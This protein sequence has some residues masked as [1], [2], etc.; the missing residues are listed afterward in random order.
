MNVIFFLLFCICAIGFLFLAPDRFLSTL[1]SGASKSATLCIAMLAGYTVWM[2][3]M[4]VWE[5]SGL[6]RGVSKRLRPLA[7]KV[8]KTTDAATLDAVC[9]N[10]SVN[11]LGI[12][13]A[14]TPYGIR[15]AALLD[16]T[17]RAEYASSLFFVLNATSIQLFPSSLVAMRTSLHSASPTDIVL[18]I[19]LSSLLSTALAVAL[20]LISRAI[21]RHAPM[22]FSRGTAFYTAKEARVK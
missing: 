6:S 20:L 17:D 21:Y 14:A 16:K 18:P 15:A 13:G 10:L 22:R 3:L 2:G 12:S 11:L 8:F 7:A 4:N 19:F 1:L 9:M 5:D